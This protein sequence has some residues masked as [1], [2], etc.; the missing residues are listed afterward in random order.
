ME[1]RQASTEQTTETPTAQPAL[2]EADRTTMSS[3]ELPPT[4]PEP[5]VTAERKQEESQQQKTSANVDSTEKNSSEVSGDDTKKEELPRP[6]ESKQN[7]TL[8][9]GQ[10]MATGKHDSQQQEQKVEQPETEQPSGEQPTEKDLNASP[11]TPAMKGEVTSVETT[12]PAQ[13]SSPEKEISN[14][15]CDV[16]PETQSLQQVVS[17][18]E[19]ESHGTVLSSSEQQEQERDKE[20]QEHTQEEQEQTQ[21]Q[22]QGQEQTQDQQDSQPPSHLYSAN[23]P[24]FTDPKDINYSTERYEALMK[25][26]RTK[27][28]REYEKQRMILTGKRDKSNRPVAFV[29]GEN[30]PKM[31]QLSLLLFFHHFFSL[32]LLP[33]FF[34]FLLYFFLKNT[35]Y[36]TSSISQLI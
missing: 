21:E 11:T 12:I 6:E 32:L 3:S 1:Q 14:K 2:E 28:F 8:D 10:K 19:A 24:N 27:D 35:V 23:H 29:I 34:A 13:S 30:L 25:E 20:E 31:Y 5:A 22:A 7:L 15:K 33:L 17:S 16:S 26:S 4:S 9:E 36:L 18:P